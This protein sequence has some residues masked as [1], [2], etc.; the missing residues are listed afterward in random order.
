MRKALCIG[1]AVNWKLVEGV[2]HIHLGTTAQVQDKR[3]WGEEFIS[4]LISVS[5]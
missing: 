4:L 3:K 5:S 2:T 1:P